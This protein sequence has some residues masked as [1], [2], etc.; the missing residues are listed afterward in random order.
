MEGRK[1]EK[2]RNLELYD[3]KQRRLIDAEVTRRSI[4]FMKRSVGP[5]SRSTPTSP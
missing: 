4:D 5:A 1:G 3:L 2:S